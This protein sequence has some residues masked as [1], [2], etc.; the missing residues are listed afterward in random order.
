MHSNSSTGSI[1]R[2]CHSEGSRRLDTSIAKSFNITHFYTQEHITKEEI[3][4]TC[5]V[6]ISSVSECTIFI[7]FYL[8]IH[9]WRQQISTNLEG[10]VSSQEIW[11]TVQF[12][13][14]LLSLRC[15]QNS[16][17]RRCQLSTLHFCLLQGIF[18]KNVLNRLEFYG[19]GY[20][21]VLQQRVSFFM[22]CN[23]S[24]ISGDCLAEI[25]SW[26]CVQMSVL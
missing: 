2:V 5:S 12:K 26:Q 11:N 10:F 6:V 14:F 8:L 16:G 18:L 3:I 20:F 25:W 19:C 24:Q 22:W 13:W 17:G 7:D 1:S 9:L 15:A 23:F 4:V 21:T